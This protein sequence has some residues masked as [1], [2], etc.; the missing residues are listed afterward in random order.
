M[1]GYGSGRRG[2][3]PKAERH[4]ALDVNQ[5]RRA[6]HLAPGAKAP[7]VWTRGGEPIGPVVLCSTGE[8]VTLGYMARLGDEPWREIED[9]IPLV[10]VPCRYGGARPYFLCPGGGGG[11]ACGRRVAK[12]WLIG[13]RFRC[14]HCH[15]ITYRGRSQRCFG[16]LF[17][18]ADKL[19]MKLGGEPGTGALLP[20]RPKGMHRTTYERHIAAIQAF[21][22][23]AWAEFGPHLVRRHP[24]EDIRGQLQAYGIEWEDEG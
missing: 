23:A 5:L 13:R 19:R 9:D 7:L 8:A 1:G 11:R 12:L 18:R 10:R 3:K 14:R 6:G 24:H 17:G 15:R 21:E 16:R 22:K 4:I 2:T 20:S